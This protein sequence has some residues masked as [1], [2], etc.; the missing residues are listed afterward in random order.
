[1]RG[2]GKR[3]WMH[4]P[5][6]K[7]ITLFF[8]KPLYINNLPPF[9]APRIFARYAC[10]GFA[11]ESFQT[12][13]S[14]RQNAQVQFNLSAGAPGAIGGCRC[15][16]IGCSRRQPPRR[17][18]RSKLE[19]S[20]AVTASQT[21]EPCRSKGDPRSNPGGKPVVGNEAAEETFEGARTAT[22]LVAALDGRLWRLPHDYTAAATVSSSRSWAA[23]ISSSSVCSGSRVAR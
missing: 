6:I 17:R 22:K 1:M 5:C 11:S 19:R 20:A 13:S 21:P 7:C 12:L 18:K 14:P 10:I 23:R 16:P 15:L 2:G 8:R 3:L 9:S 4:G